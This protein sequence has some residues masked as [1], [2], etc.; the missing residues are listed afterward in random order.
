VTPEPAYPVSGAIT[1]KGGPAAEVRVTA[2]S[3]G[4]S[5]EAG[6]EFETI[7]DEKG[8]YRFGTNTATDG[9][10]PGRYAVRVTWPDVV[11]RSDP[12]N[13]IDKLRGRFN[14]PKKPAFTIEVKETT[15]TIPPFDLK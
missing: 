5:P 2:V 3:A 7:T 8:E 13:E 14:N 9:L 12:E 6:R 15:N 11:R 1:S 10:P 4:P